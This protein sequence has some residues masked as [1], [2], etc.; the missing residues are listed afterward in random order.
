MGSPLGRTIGALCGGGD[1]WRRLI[2]VLAC[3]LDD[4]G[5]T[6]DCPVITMAGYIGLA[7]GWADFEK[8]AIE[9]Y[10]NYGIGEI[11]HARDF[12]ASDKVFK[13]WS[14]IKKQTYAREIC[15]AAKN[16]HAI[17]IGLTMSV[18]KST[19]NKRKIETGLDRAMSPYGYCF[20]VIMNDLLVDEILRQS[21]G[22]DGF[23]ISFIIEGGN[24]NDNN[25]LN[26]FNA[27][28]R[29]YNIEN[30][31]KS[32]SFMNKDSSKALQLADFFAYYSRRA[33]EKSEKNYRIPAPMDFITVQLATGFHL[34]DHVATGFFVQDPRLSAA[35][36]S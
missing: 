36:S 2:L 34:I 29:K 21:L 10:S 22:R 20:S 18:L 27:V 33:V 16:A 26:V 32:I 11:F 17:E 25:V 19:Y 9:I 14:R 28:R 1:L 4:S 23:D 31:L 13:G 12:H 5:T 30:K 6:G 3:Y 8:M 7:Q 24:K 15:D 35:Q